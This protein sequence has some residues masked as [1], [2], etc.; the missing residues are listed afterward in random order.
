MQ[1]DVTFASQGATSAATLYIPDAGD[2]P[3]PPLGM[4]GG[5]C[6]VKEIVMR[7]YAARFAENGVACLAFAYRGSGASEG[8]SRQHIDPWVQIEDAG[9][10]DQPSLAAA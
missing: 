2:A 8:D 4:G 1:R 10:G 5:W 6:Y 3:Y 7:H 9:L